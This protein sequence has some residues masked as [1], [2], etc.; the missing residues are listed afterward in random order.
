MKQI[1]EDIRSG[2]FQKCYLLYG[3][4]DYL[5]RQYRDKLL[6]ALTQPGDTMNFSRYEGE[7]ISVG[8]LIDLAETMPFFA[9]RRVILVTDSGLFKKSN[10][11]LADYLP[12]L[13]DTVCFLFVEREV[14]KR[15]RTYKAAVK[16]GTAV[17]FRMPDEKMIAR[18]M[19]G[20]LKEAGKTISKEAWAEFLSRTNDSM[21]NMDRE[22]EK[23]LSYTAQRN[24]I[25]LDD[26]Q[27]ICTQQ[28]QTKIFDMISGV[29]SRDLKKVMLL[30]QDLLAAKEPPMRILYLIVR[31]FRQLLV[32]SEL[33]RKRI[34]T[35]AIAKSLG[36]PDFAVRKN[37]GLCRNFTEQ[38]IR[39]LLKDAA[40]LEEQVKTG[41]M[42]ERMA[43]ELLMIR[44]AK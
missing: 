15:S 32:I 6:E 5:K 30:Y 31:Q 41:R 9:E 17:D 36:I 29:A 2:Q 14:D 1:D 8:E 39:Q 13:Q 4:E 11:E 23:L 10:D 22:M 38:Q 44:Y 40:E 18:W 34:D 33:T 43:V 37:L 42:D 7:G 25:S 21:E 35:S 27:A 26:V 3:E 12:Q 28:V 19:G 16:A 20:R 24:H